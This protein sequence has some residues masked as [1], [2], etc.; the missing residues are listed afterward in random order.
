MAGG[1]RPLLPDILGKNDPA[2]AKTPIFNRYS[3]VRL[4]K[5]QL[6]LIGSPQHAFQCA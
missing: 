1:G 3:L 4:E 2:G 6:S 5:V